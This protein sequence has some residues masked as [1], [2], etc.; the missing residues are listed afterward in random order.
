MCRTYGTHVYASFLNNGLKSVATKCFEPKALLIGIPKIKIPE[1]SNIH[2]LKG[3]NPYL[4]IRVQEAE[5]HPILLHMI[6][7]IFERHIFF[8]GLNSYKL[9]ASKRQSLGQFCSPGFQSGVKS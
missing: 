5:P 3:V 8:K 4:L 9:S 7:K 1:N 2:I 6:T